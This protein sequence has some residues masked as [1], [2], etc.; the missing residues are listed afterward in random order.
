MYGLPYI[1]LIDD[2]ADDLEMISAGLTAAGNRVK[3]FESP[4]KALFYLDLVSGSNDLP[5]LIIMDYNM[6]MKNGYDMLLLLKNNPD[7][8]GIP[9]VIF[10]TTVS[11]RLEE[12]MLNAGAAGC[13]TK[14]SNA[15]E[16]TLQLKVFQKLFLGFQMS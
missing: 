4:S 15:R 3:T 2:D 14:W 5:S 13:C 11:P 1:L 6:P 10:S 9:V 16:L 7:T 12:K 8:A